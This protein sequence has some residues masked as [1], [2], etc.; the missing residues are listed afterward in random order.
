MNFLQ[1]NKVEYSRL[2][3]S[4]TK[5]FYLLFFMPFERCDFVEYKRFTEEQKEKARNADIINFLGSYMGLEFKQAGK[6]YQCKQHN[7][8]VVY[9]NRKGFVWNSRNISGGDC[10]DFLNKLYGTAVT[11]RAVTALI[12]STRLRAKISLKRLKQSSVR[13]QVLHIS[14]H[15]NI[16]QRKVSLNYPN[17]QRINTAVYSLIFRKQEGFQQVL[18]PTSSSQNKYIKM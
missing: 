13:M 8:L 12:F 4:K 16:N 9:P 1:K 18:Y 7:S 3:A 17:Q 14:L 11:F 5:M 2:Q 15:H 10:I 6:Y